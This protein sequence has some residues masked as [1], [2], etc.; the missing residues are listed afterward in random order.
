MGL[1][2]DSYDIIFDLE[3]MPPYTRHLRRWVG[4]TVFLL[5]WGLGIGA[6]RV[7]EFRDI[8]YYP[9]GHFMDKATAYLPNDRLWVWYWRRV[10]DVA[11]EVYEAYHRGFAQAKTVLWASIEEIDRTWVEDP[12]PEEEKPAENADA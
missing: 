2:R 1:L 12:P 11:P 10:G 6:P 4:N 9:R 5:T 3:Q 8:R 7:Q